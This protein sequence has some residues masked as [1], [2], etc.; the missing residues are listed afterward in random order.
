MS[1]G[2]LATD[3]CNMKKQD[4]GNN[5]NLLAR[6][7]APCLVL[8]GT[9]LPAT[10]LALPEDANQPID[11]TYDS[12][13][14][15]L[16]EGKQVYYGSP[17]KPAQITQG[18]LKITGQEITIERSD[19]EVKKVTVTGTPAHYEQQPAIDQAVVTAEGET[20]I[21]DYATQHMSAIGQVRFTQGNDQWTGCQV[22]YYL[23]SRQ[24]ST[25]R[26]ADGSQAR[27]ILAPRNNQ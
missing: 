25:P 21:L 19:G 1:S 13:Q 3:K 12:S 7:F 4:R 5:M 11:V 22:D 23:E 10:M 24:L 20:I 27:V 8:A 9:S 26:C 16:D 2:N 6:L 14:L 15:L 18:T 17:E